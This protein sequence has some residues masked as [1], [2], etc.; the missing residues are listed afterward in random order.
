MTPCLDRDVHAHVR[1][2]MALIIETA[3][4]MRFVVLLHCMAS[5][6]CLESAPLPLVSFRS[7]E[8]RDALYS[9]W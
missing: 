6:L 3:R 1:A 8:E 4:K 7:K 5:Q 9:R 2:E